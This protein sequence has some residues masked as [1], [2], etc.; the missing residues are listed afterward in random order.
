MGY[1][2]LSIRP[3]HNWV[4]QAS[5]TNEGGVGRS[6]TRAASEPETQTVMRMVDEL[7]GQSR[8][9]GGIDF[10]SYGQM[11]LTQ[12]GWTYRNYSTDD[13]SQNHY[14]EMITLATQMQVR[15][16][17]FPQHTQRGVPV[18]RLPPTPVARSVGII[19]TLSEPP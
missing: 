9:A 5:R 13:V 3:P 11:I 6:G 15:G 12:P 7:N 4:A 18:G 19:N 14:R 8:L 2:V 17:S 10:H 1:A 16:R